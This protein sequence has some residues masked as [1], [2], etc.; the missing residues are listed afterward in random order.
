MTCGPRVEFM[1][2]RIQ[3]PLHAVHP[4][5]GRLRVPHQMPTSILQLWRNSFAQMNAS[6]S[7][8][9][10]TDKFCYAN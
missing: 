6:V 8:T 9:R 1:E 2:S 10:F 4:E 5:L 7:T 3:S